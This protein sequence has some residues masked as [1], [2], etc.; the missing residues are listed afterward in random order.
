MNQSPESSPRTLFRRASEQVIQETTDSDPGHR[1]TMHCF[2]SGSF[3]TANY[4]QDAWVLPCEK[5]F[6]F[7]PN[8]A[9]QQNC[10][11]TIPCIGN[12][13]LPPNGVGPNRCDGNR[14]FMS[15]S[16]QSWPRTLNMRRK[17]SANGSVTAR[18]RTVAVDGSNSRTM[19]QRMEWIRPIL[20][21]VVN[22]GAELIPT[23]LECLDQC[24]IA[25]T[26]QAGS[27]KSV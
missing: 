6:N 20:S 1:G 26:G 23:L 17:R 16:I 15:Y 25:P 21:R 7:E 2:D 4:L 5:N 27:E 10:D 24:I 3:V 13:M 11:V 14:I 8:A 22:N 12:V 9:G 19:E 18:T